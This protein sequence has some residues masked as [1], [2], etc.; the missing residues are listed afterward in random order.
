MAP[1]QR[2]AI[3]GIGGLGHFAV[4]LGRE[5][6]AEVTAVDISEE[7]LDLAKSLGAMSVLNA[8]A[9]NVVRELR[10]KGGVHVALVTSPA[11][12]TYDVAFGCLRPMGMLLVVGLPSENLS[13]PAILMAAGE[14][15]IQA[16]AVGTRQ[17]LR[18]VL[19]L[20]A[21]GK[22]HCHVTAHPLGEINEVLD[23]L[24]HG[25]I[26]GRTAIVFS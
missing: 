22:L 4:Q 11:K 24:R 8:A 25:Q 16:S 2:L 26:S 7:K 20:G 10:S 3:F 15:R 19:E 23:Q 13:F 18:E 9:T 6:G 1:G 21:A 5:L 17:D 14:V 12:A